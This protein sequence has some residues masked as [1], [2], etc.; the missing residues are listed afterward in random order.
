MNAQN[1]IQPSRGFRFLRL[2]AELRV[3]IYRLALCSNKPINPRSTSANL[4]A[5][6]LRTCRQVHAEGK[7]ILYDENTFQIELSNTL[8]LCHSG[9]IVPTV[10]ADFYAQRRRVTPPLLRLHIQVRYTEA[11]KLSILRENVMWLVDRLREQQLPIRSLQLD[12][13]LHCHDETEAE[14]DGGAYAAPY[15]SS[16]LFE[17]SDIDQCRYMLR[18]WFGRL[19][20]IREVTINGMT[21]ADTEAMRER[22]QRETLTREEAKARTLLDRFLVLS[23]YA[24]DIYFCEQDLRAALLAAEDDDVPSF[25]A[26]QA[27]ILR[28]VA[29]HLKKMTK[30][31]RKKNPR[32]RKNRH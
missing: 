17:A 24:K 5:Q 16:H 3:M 1:T 6:L 15:L 12:C 23:E 9:R 14:D 8:G 10:L 21:E 18:S 20:G 30:A 7:V 13:D 28:S 4:S 31:I 25:E 22:M 29:K 27:R 11:H 19:R 2:P 32:V 26:A